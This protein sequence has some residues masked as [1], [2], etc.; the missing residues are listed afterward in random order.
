MNEHH[1]L[2]ALN[3]VP[4]KQLFQNLSVKELID[5]A[6]KKDEG[7]LAGN[8]AL[9]V[10]TG[11][12]T[13]RSPFDRF[14]VEDEETK[15]NV[16]WNLVNRPV[17]EELFDKIYQ[18]ATEF[19]S[20]NDI[21]VFDGFAGNDERYRL[22]I[23]VV[24]TK[25]WHSLFATT[26]FVRPKKEELDGHEAGFTVVNA[27][28]LDLNK[29]ELGLKSKAFIAVN[30]KKKIILVTGSSYGG[31]MKK[32]IFAVMNYLLPPKNVFPMH[33][34]AN[35]GEALDTALFFGLSG[36][37]KTTLSADP[38]R[39]LI[40]DDEHGWTDFGIFNFEGGCYAKAINLSQEAEPQIFDAI[41]SGSILEN[42]I[43]KDDG[44]VDYDS[45]KI[46][47]NTRA[48][49]PLDHIPNA[50]VSGMGDH[51]KNIFFLTCDA[52]GVL[53]PI[54]KLNPN[55]AMYHFISGYTAKVAGT[56]VGI[57]E[58]SAT[59][60]ACFGAPFL[61]RHPG[62]YAKLLGEKM[63]KHKTNVWLLNTGWSKGAFGVGKRMKIAI[64]RA[65]ISAALSG[66]IDNV[67][68]S[69]DPNFNVLIPESCEGVASE[70]L[71]PKNTWADKS[72]YDVTAKKL[73]TLFKE[74]FKKFEDGVSKEIILAGP[75]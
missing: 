72:A 71:V 31:E 63:Q 66:K 68:Y 5:I 67:E 23:R 6:L 29:D 51:P 47:A 4:K 32:G 40:G 70:M 44:S 50:V 56:E 7:T 33:C 48:T 20:S 16:D 36:T 54:S 37:G 28:G 75:K 3:I 69:T 38:L 62:I 30:F 58:P 64:T 24:T 73:S 11:E 15:K 43:L 22:P 12:R 59:F 52:F 1:I 60:S 19:I 26:L 35:I 49:Y 18:L 53:P 21:F 9:V 41:R 57:T 46:T 39:K 61:P 8:G 55:Q 45:D 74:N 42:V 2:D 65:L 13:G 27:F 25:A 34:S 10:R 14:I 17:S